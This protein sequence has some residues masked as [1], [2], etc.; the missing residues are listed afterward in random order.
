MTLPSSGTLTMAQINAEFGRGN[1]LNSYRGT[2]WYTDAGASG[3]FS[4]GTISFNDFYGKRL[5]SPT[6]TFSISSNQTNANLRS[7]AVSAGWNQSSA[8]VATLNSGVVISS[9]GTGTPALTINGSFPGGVT[10]T[11]NGVIVGR[12]G[13]GGNGSPR[14][15][16]LF[17]RAGDGGGGGGALSV[18]T[19]VTINNG[20]GTIAGG[21][22]GG[23]GGGGWTGDAYGCSKEGCYVY[24]FD[25]G[26]GGGGGGR[27]SLAANAS[28]GAYQ[29]E[30]GQGFSNATDGTYYGAGT[31]GRTGYVSYG[32]NGG[33]W[34][35]GGGNGYSAGYSSTQGGFGG[36]GGYAVSGNGY[37]TWTATGTR[38][39][40][41]G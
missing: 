29:D 21:G 22:G 24:Y 1:N 18:S 17:R 30:Q 38:Y 41:I 6:F 26:G 20:S 14:N 35:S 16:G 19:S 13:N 27:S 3:T 25:V 15:N 31:G 36:S 34:G 5:T 12:G 32:G 2:T 23:G 7:L 10:F 37:I 11:N 4:S 33:G 8:V 39:G 40:S 9:D 28:A